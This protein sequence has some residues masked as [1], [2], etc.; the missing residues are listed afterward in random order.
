MGAFLVVLPQPITRHFLHFRKRFKKLEVQNLFPE[1]LVE[2]FNICI[3]R[4]L[5][6]L[7]ELQSTRFFSLQSAKSTE[8]SSG[9]L[10]ISSLAGRPRGPLLALKPVRPLLLA[11]RIHF[12]RQTLTA[13][14]IQNVECP[15]LLTAGQR[16][17]HE[18]NGPADIGAGQDHQWL[19]GP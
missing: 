6:W 15:E 1:R 18:V 11:V 4:G 10:S 13:E 7:D 17:M 19:R 8:I 9:P 14:V 5:A 16:V 3:L 12:D 2:P